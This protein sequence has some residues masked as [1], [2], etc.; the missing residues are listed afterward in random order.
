MIFIFFLLFSTS[1]F[2]AILENGWSVVACKPEAFAGGSTLAIKDITEFGTLWNTASNRGNTIE[3]SGSMPAGAEWTPSDFGGHPVFSTT[4]DQRDGTIYTVTTSLYNLVSTAPTPATIYK[5]DNITGS[6]PQVLATLPGNAGGGFLDIDVTHNQLFVIDMD[7]GT[8]HRVGLDG[9]LLSS[10]DP[11]SIDDGLTRFPPLGERLLGVAYHS[12]ENRVYYSVW[13]DDAIN[14]GNPN[15]V[16][17]IGLNASGDFNPAS[18]DV[19]EISLTTNQPVADIEFNSTYTSVLLAETGFDSSV[20]IIFPH[21]ATVTEWSGGTGSW[22]QVGGNSY[23]GIGQNAEN[24]ARGGVAWAYSTAP[25]GGGVTGLDDFIL[26]TA[27]AI[28]W[29]NPNIYGYQFIPRNNPPRDVFNSIVAD[30]DGEVV[31]PRLDKNIYGD[32]DIY[33]VPDNT[34]SCPDPSSPGQTIPPI[35]TSITAG[36]PDEF[37]TSLNNPEETV[38]SAE[39]QAIIDNYATVNNNFINSRANRPF[40]VLSDN[41]FFGHTFSGLPANIIDASLEVRLKGATEIVDNDAIGLL[42]STGSI[43]WNRSIKDL[44]EAGGTWLQNQDVVFNLNLQQLP[45]DS[46]DID[47]LVNLNNDLTLDVFVQDDTA[48]D[49]MTLNVASCPSDVDIAID[50]QRLRTT[51]PPAPG[52]QVD[53]QVTVTNLGPGTATNVVVNDLLPADFVSISSSI[54][55]PPAAYDS[56]TGKMNIP[57][58]LPQEAVILS[59]SATLDN[60]LACGEIINTASL[61]SVDQTDTNSENNQ[62]IDEFQLPPCVSCVDPVNTRVG[63]Q[64]R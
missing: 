9:T 2:A 64:V 3:H 53:Y 21:D 16:R 22:N 4:I 29:P 56:S 57:A 33:L 43:G 27:D 30:L 35:L 1:V 8:I 63:H 17:S 59:V 54:S 40:D 25:I 45:N 28:H 61:G 14:N 19:L 36:V 26:V 13:A 49:Y 46:G 24:N 62:A 58:L 37:D 15:V 32:V 41:Q 39:L 60:N 51:S 20:P 47:F 48:V 7:S 12:A 5:I 50:K 52:S 55:G 18:D 10:Y 6:V 23:Y 34:T 42:D 38:R 31:D 11:L 44:P